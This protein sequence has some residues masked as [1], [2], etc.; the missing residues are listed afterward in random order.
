LI[1]LQ[2][3]SQEMREGGMR[4]GSIVL[5]HAVIRPP[6]DI[7]ERLQLQ[8][9][10][11]VFKLRRLRLADK[12]PIA[13]EIS[14]TPEKYFPGI[15]SIDFGRE[16][17][18]AVLQKRFGLSIGWSVD[19][20]EAARATAEEA[21]LLT[22]PH[23]SAILAIARLVMSPDGR[24]VEACLSRYRSDRYRATVRIPR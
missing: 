20:I 1:S 3:F 23:G 12:V 7:V 15:G 9:D 10:D 14:Y 13:V 4:P 2:G 21:R 5:E 24:P 17:L 18:Y 22:I 6:A 11:K 16:S 19:V 8:R